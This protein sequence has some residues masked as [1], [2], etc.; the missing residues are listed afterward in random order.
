MLTGLCSL[1]QIII[2]RFFDPMMDDKDLIKALFFLQML[3]R[4]QA[5]L[6]QHS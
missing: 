6:H 1:Q 3:D 4:I 5:L 2:L